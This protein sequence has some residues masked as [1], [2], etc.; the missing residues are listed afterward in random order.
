MTRAERL[1]AILDLLA[2]RGSL[3]VEDLVEELGISPATARRDLDSLAQQRLLT[4]TRGGATASAVAYDLPVKY[5]RDDF[6][7]RKLAIAHAASALIEEGDVV[8]LCGGTTSTALAGVLATREDLNRAT[9]GPTLTVVTNAINIAAQLA[10]R[11]NFKIMVT[12]GI[13]NP[14]SYE[15]VGPF[16]DVVLQKVTI[17]KAFIGVNG[18]DPITGPTITDEGE[19]AVNTFIAS[20]ARDAYVVADA[21]KIGRRAF[22]AMADFDFRHLITDSSVAPEALEALRAAGVEVTVAPDLAA[23]AS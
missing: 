22:A 14:R 18:I 15:L 6:A 16:T 21:S 8:G 2:A 19:A 20:R 4:R 13:L 23:A 17:D 5:H 11:P 3:S 9:H 12:G 1:A 7:G 10:V